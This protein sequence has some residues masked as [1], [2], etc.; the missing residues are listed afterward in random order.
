MWTAANE[1]LATLAGYVTSYSQLFNIK[2]RKTG[3]VPNQSFIRNYS[4]DDYS[5]YAQDTWRV[6][7]RVTLTLGVRYTL[8]SAADERDSL[9]LLPVVTNNNAQA[10][11]LSNATLD[12][13]GA[14]AGR[15]LYNRDKNNF[16][17]NLG[18][19]WDV[20][21][22]GKTALRG[23]YSVSFVNDQ[24][25]LAPITI[26]GFN[27]GIVSTAFDSGFTGRISS[28]PPKII[29][30]TFKVPR[31]T[32]D[33]YYEDSGNALGLTD[34]NLRTP[35]VQQWNIG[36]QQEFKG[37]IFEARYVGNHATKGYRAFDYNQVMIRENGF[38]DDFKRA[39]NNGFLAQTAT[40]TF[41]P[42]YDAKIPGSQQLTVFPKLYRSG[43]LN[44]S[45][46][47]SLIQSG[48]VG[49]L[50]ASYQMD[51]N[52]GPVNFFRN[53]YTLGAD[54]L[55]NYSNST[56]N[57]LQLEVRRRLSADFD[58]Q[59]N[60]T[61]SKVLSDSAGTSQ[62]RLEHFLDLENAKLERSRADF[63]LTHAIK[64]SSV[65]ELP[66]LKRNRW[67]GGWSVSGIMIWQSGTPFSVLSQRGT[68]NRSS[69]SRS[70]NNTA[71]TV[72]TK[73]QTDVIFQFR[74]TGDGPMFVPASVIGPDGRA[75]SGDGEAAFAGQ[76]FFNPGPGEVGSLQRRMFSGP[77]AFN[78]D[79]GILK[80]TKLTERQSIEFRM[81][82]TNAL[83]HPQFMVGDQNINSTEFGR[84]SETF[85]TA[86]RIQFGLYYRF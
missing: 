42:A 10:T 70:E 16:A 4:F 23:G 44:N 68:L 69:G 20:F 25:L 3:F 58:F 33:N 51:G 67:L 75:V 46:N 29:T 13:A 71:N 79:F 53:P 55:T 2:D 49:E 9:L 52:N 17:P 60:Y 21:G 72:L 34:P 80:T 7:P 63:D 57:S 85:S 43:Q 38:L 78:I 62:S 73:P 54:Y 28:T 66:V 35:Y 86:R 61:F 39:Q 45:T 19:A 84:I 74:Q 48:S 47:R 36:I 32:E 14:A 15:P 8:Y 37:T 24:G 50:A 59:A 56:Y 6:R 65:Y 40:G 81:E 27:A 41:N 31:T 83:N 12:F 76:R 82:S 5:L 30:P 11:L 77:W 64:A 18:L 1:L 22:N 26:A